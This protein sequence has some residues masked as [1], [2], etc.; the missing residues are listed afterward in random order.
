MEPLAFC[1]L[2]SSVVLL[3]LLGLKALRPCRHHSPDGISVDIDKAEAFER[4]HEALKTCNAMACF[5]FQALDEQSSCVSWTYS[6]DK[7]TTDEL[8]ALERI[9]HLT[10]D[11]IKLVLES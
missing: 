2:A 9:R 11:W 1:A 4:L 3:S 10:D 7:F 5:E 6:Y 8:E